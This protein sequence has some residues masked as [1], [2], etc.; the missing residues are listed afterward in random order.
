[1]SRTEGQWKKGVGLITPSEDVPILLLNSYLNF[2]G[3][4]IGESGYGIRDNDGTLQ[5][6]NSGGSWANLG[7]GGSGSGDFLADGSVP[8][9]GDFNA[10]GNDLINVNSV[11]FD[12]TPT[13]NNTI[14]SMQWNATDDTMDVQGT[15]VRLQLGQ[16][17]SPLYK[18]QTGSTI[19]NGRPVMFSG[20]IGASG[21]IAI[22]YALADGSMPPYYIVGV[23][24]EEIAN[25]AD[26]HVT[27]FGKVRGIDT[28]GTPFGE[29]WVEGDELYVSPTTP[30]AF[31]KV[32]PSA[33]DYIISVAV[34]VNVHAVT[35]T[36][37][38]RPSWNPK[39]E[40]LSDVNG[41]PLSTSGQFPV[42][43]DTTGV[44]DF[45]ANIDDFAPALGADDNYVTD[46]EK[47]KLSNIS[48]TQPVDLDNLEERMFYYSV[49]F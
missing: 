41:T 9:T 48:V 18:N 32:R 12:T 21:N 47:V 45:T 24:T 36:L 27:W 49:T 30:G 10:D 38:I 6:K 35:G 39:L 20:G 28:T 8:M 46:A 43:N 19:A 17:I 3:T 29:T 42:W 5:F 40:D 37:F 16:E 23:T 4:L 22:E 2:G 1:M 31:T 13:T 25:G 11:Q 7:S 44:F 33:P 34:V 14:G 26:G 15:N